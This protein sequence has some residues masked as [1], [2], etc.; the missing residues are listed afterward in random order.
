M[1]E[2]RC[3]KDEDDEEEATTGQAACAAHACVHWPPKAQQR[4]NASVC[5]CWYAPTRACMRMC[6][7]AC[8]RCVPHVVH[9]SLH[10]RLQWRVKA[11]K[12]KC[13][14]VCCY[15]WLVIYAQLLSD[16][17]DE[18]V[19]W[20]RALNDTVCT[21]A[22]MHACRYVPACVCHYAYACEGARTCLRSRYQRL[23]RPPC[24]HITS[25][26]PSPQLGPTA[27]LAGRRLK[28]YTPKHDLSMA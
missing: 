28:K 27:S 15:W 3:A 13:V 23:I 2:Y 25:S 26:S 6:I 9:A 24:R 22:C 5:H 14:C 1:A 20:Y 10:V 17:R 19:T 8:L 12:R 18:C 21:C 7:T 16:E 4:V 11:K